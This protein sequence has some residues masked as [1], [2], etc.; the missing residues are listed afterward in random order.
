VTV[1]T[2]KV[3]LAGESAGAIQQ[4]DAVKETR[5]V[6]HWCSNCGAQLHPLEGPHT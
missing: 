2:E 6:R 4:A 1:E 3:F 5:A